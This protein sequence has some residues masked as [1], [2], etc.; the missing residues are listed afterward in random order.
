[1]TGGSVAYR[2]KA[3]KASFNQLELE[4][5]DVDERDEDEEEEREDELLESIALSC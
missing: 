4:V 2:R 1:M 5:E 3:L